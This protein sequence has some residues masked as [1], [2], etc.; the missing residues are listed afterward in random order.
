MN[1][2]NK[3]S[4]VRQSYIQ[5]VYNARM[6]VSTPIDLYIDSDKRRKEK[7]EKRKLKEVTPKTN[8]DDDHD[9]VKKQ[10]RGIK[11]NRMF[12]VLFSLSLS[13]KK[14]ASL[15]TLQIY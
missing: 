2:Y 8:A 9:I 3:K 13:L 7:Q 4:D 12:C 14:N 15:F 5:R 11:S 1:S 6:S 10:T